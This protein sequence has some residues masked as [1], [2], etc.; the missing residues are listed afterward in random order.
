[1]SK[2]NRIKKQSSLLARFLKR[3]ILRVFYITFLAVLLFVFKSSSALETAYDYW[4]FCFSIVF[5]FEIIND[6]L[7]LFKDEKKE[8]S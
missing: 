2:K 8:Q 6:L 5:I 4:N 1:M 7:G 3:I